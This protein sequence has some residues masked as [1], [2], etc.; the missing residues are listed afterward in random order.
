[1]KKTYS[2]SELKGFA[3]KV[4]EQY[5]TENEAFA[6]SDGNVFLV[7]NRAELHAGPK[8]NIYPFKREVKTEGVVLKANDAI[9]AI[10]KCETLE[11]LEVFKSD[12]RKSVK[13]AFAKKSEELTKLIEDANTGDATDAG[14]Q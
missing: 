1:M 11:G 10:A 3:D 6:T 13:E 14:K 2:E 4:F 12:E 5:P 7:K 8:G 9:A